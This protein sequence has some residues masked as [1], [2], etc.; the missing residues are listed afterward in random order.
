M[1]GD[2]RPARPWTVAEAVRWTVD[3][4][5]LWRCIAARKNGRKAGAQLRPPRKS[6]DVK[7]ENA[8]HSESNSQVQ[9]NVLDEMR[10]SALE[11]ENALHLHLKSG[12]LVALGRCGNPDGQVKPVEPSAWD[13]LKFESLRQ[14]VVSEGPPAQMLIFDVQLYVALDAPDA[15]GYLAGKTMVE[16]LREFVFGDPQALTL[17]ERAKAKAGRPMEPGFRRGLLS[18]FW[19]L[20]CGGPTWERFLFFWEN[21]RD[22]VARRLEHQANI[23]LGRRFA[24]LV[25]HLSA[26]HLVAEGI[27]R[28]G[29]SAVAIP[30]SLWVHERMH[31]DVVNG[32]LVE[33][34]PDAESPKDEWSTM[35]TGLV[36]RKADVPASVFHGKPKTHDVVRLHTTAPQTTALRKGIMGAEAQAAARSACSEWLD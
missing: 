20:Y 23:V 29:R 33:L 15:V 34:L 32:D 4:A 3:P 14:S 16:A 25:E 26:G 31:I 9:R 13:Y 12:R 35:F 17:R 24:K 22:P 1:T 5:V 7:D 28:S 36:L 10:S 19:P 11:V 8:P 21:T 18:T 30:R 2:N 27:D 6:T